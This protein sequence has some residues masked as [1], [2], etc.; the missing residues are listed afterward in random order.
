M[1]YHKV[2][3]GP[4]ENQLR[5]LV[6]GTEVKLSQGHMK[7]DVEMHLTTTQVKKLQAAAKS[8]RGCTIKM[9]KAQVKHH[10]MHGA[11]ILSD[12]ARGAF[13]M[14]K[15]VLRSGLGSALD[16]GKNKLQ[17]TIENA[18][19]IQQGGSF[20]GDIVPVLARVGSLFGAG[21][22]P[23]KPKKLKGG[24]FLGDAGKFLGHGAVDFLANQLG[25]SMQPNPMENSNEG[26]MQALYQKKIQQGVGL[27]Q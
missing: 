18:A 21:I 9:T 1:V 23:K 8:G 12:L 5:D 24:S 7:G 4:S 14:L 27:Y 16:F 20:L 22:K 17:G 19:G 2:Q 15:P 25:G 10:A 26:L 3:L 13:E 11:G 6:Q